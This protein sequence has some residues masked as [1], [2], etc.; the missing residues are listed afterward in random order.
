MS[1]DNPAVVV[2]AGPAGLCAAIELAKAG[3]P[4]VLI[5]ENS[6]PGGQLFKQIHK[7]F[8]SREH[9]AGTR[10]VTIGTELLEESA[11]LGIDVR[12]E[13][14]VVGASMDLEIWAVEKGCRSYQL[15]AS[16]VILAT[17]ATEN[18]LRFAGWTLPGVMTAGCAQTMIN[19]QRVLP[20]RRV[21]MVG[22]GNVG[23]I[24]AYQLMQ[25]GA[26]V[27]GIVEAAPT[28]GGYGVH[29][30]KVRRAGVPF[31]TGTT[32]ARA[33]GAESV[34]RAVLVDLDGK[35]NPVPGTERS[36]AV[37][38]I[39]VAVGL[40]PLGDLA[41]LLGCR[42]V[43]ISDLGGYMPVHDEYMRSSRE[44]VYVAGDLAGIEEA[45]TAMEEGRLAGLHAAYSMGY[46]DEA[47]LDIRQRAEAALQLGIGIVGDHVLFL[48][49]LISSRPFSQ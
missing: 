22:S 47:G 10:G 25:A 18:A 37:D 6:R 11:K 48:R 1:G 5:D 15:P 30:A 32:I 21:L 13:T 49:P 46:L 44:G 41:Q 26:E 43:F 3:A 14:E 29:T 23:V 34:E 19:V 2:G 38:A 20:G 42:S 36:V 8:G 4:V 39:C 40:T 45:S 16:R 24:V 9:R 12:L 31:Y 27:V 28:L 7:F 33:E 35:F 17:G